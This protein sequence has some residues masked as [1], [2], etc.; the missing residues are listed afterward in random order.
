MVAQ[1]SQGFGWIYLN[2]CQPPLE[3]SEGVG[4]PCVCFGHAARYLVFEVLSVGSDLVSEKDHAVDPL[5]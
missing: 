1:L 2:D 4:G 5:D 3:S